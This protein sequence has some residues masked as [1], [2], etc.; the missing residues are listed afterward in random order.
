MDSETFTNVINED[1]PFTPLE[2]AKLASLIEMMALDQRRMMVEYEK[3]RRMDKW[4][5]W[6]L[7][8]QCFLLG[9]VFARL[10]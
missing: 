4:M 7:Y 1:R 2:R 9:W 5:E 8:A 10:W 6:G 3:M